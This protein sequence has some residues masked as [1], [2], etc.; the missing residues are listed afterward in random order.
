[1]RPR[2]AHARAASDA[3]PS[4]APVLRLQGHHR[5]PRQG[6]R[7]RAAPARRRAPRREAGGEEEGEE[8]ELDPLVRTTKART[9]EERLP[10]PGESICLVSS[11]HAA[12]QARKT[13]LNVS[14][15]KTR[16]RIAPTGR[17]GS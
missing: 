7:R 1:A 3:P 17:K 6:R 5:L 16:L 12:G 9:S 13:F 8:V 14:L 15:F 11:R 10:S 2:H 4:H